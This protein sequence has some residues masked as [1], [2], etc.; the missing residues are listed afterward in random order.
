M[1]LDQLHS[2]FLSQLVRKLPSL[3]WLSKTGCRDGESSCANFI[4]L[5]KIDQAETFS[6][7]EAVYAVMH[8]HQVGIQNTHA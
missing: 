6:Y 4:E 3:F 2:S 1:V 5:G 8:V 7:K